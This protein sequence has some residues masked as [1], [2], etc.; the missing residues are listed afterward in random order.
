M[1]T[2]NIG[3][4]LHRL[5]RDRDLFLEELSK[6]LDGAISTSTLSRMETQESALTPRHLKTLANFYEITVADIYREAEGLGMA[7][8]D[9]SGAK[10]IP[11]INWVQAGEWTE[12]PDSTHPSDCD[13]WTVA[14][15]S[16]SRNAFAL[17]VK[18]DSMQAPTGMSF[19]EGMIIVVD[20]DKEAHDKSFVVAR[21]NETD[22]CTFKQLVFDGPNRYLKALNQGYKPIEITSDTRI[23]GVVTRLTWD[24]DDS[25][26]PF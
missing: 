9:I 5:R 10:K 3:P 4:V 17:R 13:S 21:F 16:A 2:I 6:K 1:K 14:P 22:E 25:G 23:C 11:V 7:D 15:P 12:T 20:P 24:Q 18:G 19:P 8:P 26:Y